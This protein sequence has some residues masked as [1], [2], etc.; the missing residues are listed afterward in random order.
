MN[1]VGYTDDQS[2]I[3]L[4]SVKLSDKMN[5]LLIGQDMPFDYLG[6]ITQLH[7]LDTDVCVA[8]Q[9]KYLQVGL[10]SI[11]STQSNLRVPGQLSNST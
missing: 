9:R 11:L 1:D 5:Q 8:N 10:H 3:D 7:K 4:L 2:K 6:Y